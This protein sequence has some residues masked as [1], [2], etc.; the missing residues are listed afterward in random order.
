MAPLSLCSLTASSRATKK[1]RPTRIRDCVM[2]KLKEALSL[3][4]AL[5][6]TSVT[7]DDVSDRLTKDV[8]EKKAIVKMID[9]AKAAV[10][11]QHIKDLIRKVDSIKL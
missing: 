9:D 4:N 3:M 10:E 7:I 6:N 8:A 11:L 2:K 1:L 5:C